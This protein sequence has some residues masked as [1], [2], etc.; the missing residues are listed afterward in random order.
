[1]DKYEEVN[2]SMKN[3]INQNNPKIHP[4]KC[5]PPTHIY[6]IA[7]S[8]DLVQELQGFVWF[9][10]FKATFNNISVISWWSV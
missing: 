6:M 9:M 1:M 2:W 7:Q 10:V 5:I 8:T 4:E 3:K